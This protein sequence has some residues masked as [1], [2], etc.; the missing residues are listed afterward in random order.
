M[1]LGRG[2]KKERKKKGIGLDKRDIDFSFGFLYSTLLVRDMYELFEC[3]R[4][5]LEF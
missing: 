4:K 2:K 5:D 1:N 3:L